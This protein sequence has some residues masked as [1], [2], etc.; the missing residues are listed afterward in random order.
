MKGGGSGVKDVAGNALAADFTWSFTTASPPP[1]PDE[2]PGGPIL[3]IAKASNPFSRYYAE[4]LRA[5]GLNAFTVTDIATS[6]PRCSRL[7]RRRS[8]A[9]CR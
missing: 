5:E 3:V 1:R 8:S 6:R 9:R 7:R 4:I 2:G